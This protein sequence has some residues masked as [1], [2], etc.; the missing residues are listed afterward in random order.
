LGLSVVGLGVTVSSLSCASDSDC[1]S[2]TSR[3][4]LGAAGMLALF[5]SWAYGM[6]DADDAARRFNASHGLETTRVG[7]VVAPVRGDKGGSVFRLDF[8]G[9]TKREV[10]GGHAG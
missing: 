8:L 4:T 2:T 7:P 5:G 10:N 6:F 9:R 1:D 3:P